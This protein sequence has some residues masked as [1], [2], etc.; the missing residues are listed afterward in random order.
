MIGRFFLSEN[1]KFIVVAI[2]ELDLSGRLGSIRAPCDGSLIP[3]AKTQQF[4]ESSDPRF[5]AV[6]CVCCVELTGKK[7]AGSS[8][9]YCRGKYHGTWQFLNR[10]KRVVTCVRNAFKRCVLFLFINQVNSQ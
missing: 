5:I 3:L 8:F 10:V 2:R 9:F 4:G 7:A 1:M 6:T